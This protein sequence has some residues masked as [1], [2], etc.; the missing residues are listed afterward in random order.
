MDKDNW[1][2]IAMLPEDYET[3]RNIVRKIKERTYDPSDGDLLNEIC[4]R[5]VHC[6]K[7]EVI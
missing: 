2:A 3:L 6:R 7:G 5:M 1:A 4:D